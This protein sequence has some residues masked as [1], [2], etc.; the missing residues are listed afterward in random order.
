MWKGIR[1]RRE[2]YRGQGDY[3]RLLGKE[4]RPKDCSDS[5]CSINGPDMELKPSCGAPR[6][7]GAETSLWLGQ[8][9]DDGPVS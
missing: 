1:G 2:E 8:V 7:K 4:Q 3:V 6:E 9:R 5:G